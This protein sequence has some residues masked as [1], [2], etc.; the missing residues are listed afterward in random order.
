MHTDSMRQPVARSTIGVFA[1]VLG[2]VLLS[3]ALISPAA[4]PAARGLTT[5]LQ[6]GPDFQGADAAQRTLWLG[7]T[8]DAGAGI[9]RFAVTWPQIAPAAQRPADPTNPGSHVQC[10]DA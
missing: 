7:R 9:A 3:A 5:G 8:A 10:R 4:S 6:G 2:T 1:L